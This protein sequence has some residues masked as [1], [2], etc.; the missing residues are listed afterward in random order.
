MCIKCSRFLIFSSLF[1]NKIRVKSRAAKGYRE[2]H[3]SPS[4]YGD[5]GKTWSHCSHLSPWVI[6]SQNS[7]WFLLLLFVFFYLTRLPLPLDFL[8]DIFLW[9][10]CTTANNHSQCFYIH[11]RLMLCNVLE[12]I[13]ALAFSYLLSGSFL[14]H[15]FLRLQIC[16]IFTS[17]WS[18]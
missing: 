12:S 3:L 5:T 17:K 4:H 13:R 7:D 14:W 1:K 10:M 18:F 9:L 8:P 16:Q 6:C 15:I 2:L 11:R